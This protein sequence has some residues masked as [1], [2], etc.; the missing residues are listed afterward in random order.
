MLFG[1]LDDDDDVRRALARLLRSWG[2][3]VSLFAS[4]EDYEEASLLAD[5]LIVDMRLP[6]INGLELHERLLAGATPVPFVLI[7][8]DDRSDISGPR[9]PPTVMK[10]F[11]EGTLMAAI[12]D[13]LFTTGRCECP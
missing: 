1:V 5:C 9:R 6:G 3:D 10:P 13:A 8:G 2:H 11:D 7:S 12:S 4:A